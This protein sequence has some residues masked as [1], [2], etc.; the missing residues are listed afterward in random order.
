MAEKIIRDMLYPIHKRTGKEREKGGGL[1]YEYDSFT[2][3]GC[4]ENK[5]D[6]GEIRMTQRMRSQ[7]IRIYC[8]S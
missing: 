1:V 7:K 2:K 3:T 8:Q 5:V 6:T 4:R